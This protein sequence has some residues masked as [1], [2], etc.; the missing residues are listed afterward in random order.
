MMFQEHLE[1]NNWTLSYPAFGL[2]FFPHTI[3]GCLPHVCCKQLQSLLLLRLSLSTSKLV[4]FNHCL[5]WGRKDE[6]QLL[7]PFKWF[8]LFFFL[9]HILSLVVPSFLHLPY[10]MGAS[11]NSLMLKLQVTSL[12]KW[13]YNVKCLY[14]V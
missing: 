8:S 1:S 11:A 4:L 7:P 13:P 12:D 10:F 2:Y 9:F 5:L 3:Y 14:F 6:I